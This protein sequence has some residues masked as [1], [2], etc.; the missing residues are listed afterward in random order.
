MTD[1]ADQNRIISE[2]NS[3]DSSEQI[4]GRFEMLDIFQRKLRQA[5][6]V[7]ETIEIT[8]H[9]IDSI[10][11]FKAKGCWLV[12]KTDGA[13][14][15]LKTEGSEDYETLEI[16]VKAAIKEGTFAWALKQQKPFYWD[17]TAD[18]SKRVFLHALSTRER[19]FGMFFGSFEDPS[20]ERQHM[21][22]T[23]ISLTLT[24]MST[25]LDSIA[26]RDELEH[27][28]KSLEK[29]V[30]RRTSAYLAAK[31]EAEK[32]SK[33]KTEFLAMM[34]HELR[35]PM[36]GVI[37]FA[38]LLMETNLD[39][40]QREF[41]NTIR[42]S[43]DSLLSIINEI[44]DY[45]KIEAGREELD[46]IPFKW[47]DLVTDIIDVS[48]HFIIGKNIEFIQQYQEG[49]PI[50]I[51][52]DVG[53]IRQILLNL[54]SNATKFTQEGSITIS[55]SQDTGIHN[56]GEFVFAISDTGIG[57]EKEI[58]SRL[59]TPFTQGDN[60]TRRKFGGTGLGLAISQSLAQ[61]MGGSID[62]ESTLGKGSTFKFTALLEAY[63]SDSDLKQETPS[64]NRQNQKPLYNAT[65]LIVED[66]SD[67]QRVIKHILN[68]LGLV[69]EIANNGLEAVS[70]AKKRTFDILFMDC[71]MPEMDGFQATGL[72][73]K[74]EEESGGHQTI[75][76]L[77][78]M[79]LK[80]DKARCL[81]AGMDDYLPKPIDLNSL[82]EV[83]DRWLPKE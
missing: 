21:L 16:L 5:T 56:N 39:E 64:I 4:V 41:I 28:N 6:T 7:Q 63:S 70:I 36:N 18:G 29:I 69:A 59:F 3:N 12:N 53:K 74:F 30:Q 55:V 68:K 10:Y 47:K 17:L 27:Q 48:R 38:S 2:T 44:L 37:G 35:T 50:Y 82:T 66:N 13:F 32:A 23:H 46:I 57:I 22:F 15:L 34:S 45:S 11:R 79:A 78:A 24:A 9:E 31:E 52:G 42:S 58:Q 43:G 54:V 14:D 49:I 40:E 51:Q 81:N 80:G 61:L 33:A 60:S 19:T 25:K 65:A 26:L 62:L 83:L 73:R 75:I 8:E 1:T 20:L 76:A 67:N 72:I 77:T 71:Q